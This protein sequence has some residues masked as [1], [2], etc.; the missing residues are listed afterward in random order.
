M[1]HSNGT[2]A[3]IKYV[4]NL[5]LFENVVLFDVLVVPEYRVS[6]LSVNKLIR[7]SRMFVGFTESKSYIPDFHLNKIVGTSS[8]NDGL[9]M[10]DSNSLISSNSQTIGNLNG[11]CFV[12]KSL[13]HNTLGHPSDQ[14]IDV[15]QSDLKFTKDSHI[16]PCDICHK[17]KQTR[18]PF[19]LSD[20]KT[21]VIGELVHID[22][23]EP[24]KVISKYSF[25]LGIVHQTTRAYTPQ[26]NEV[27]EKKHKHLLNV[28]KMCSYWFSTTK[29]AYK[30]YSRESKLVFYSRDVK[31]YET[32]F[33][34]NMKSSLQFLKENHVNNIKNLIFFN[35]KH[36]DD[37]T[38]SLSPYDDGR[39]SSAPNDDGN[40]QPCT[41]G[42][43]NRNNNWTICDLPKGR[44]AVGSKW[45]FK[46]KY[47][48]TGAIDR[49]KARLVAKGFNQRDGFDYM[50]TFSPV[51]KMST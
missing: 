40:V 50:E 37:Q 27:A 13:W 49:Y 39:V 18:E 42:S 1:V 8:E 29:K 43:L 4:G 31:F 30:L 26:Q 22:L 36:L 21:T 41:T 46:I 34:Y 17:T 9:Y 20:H 25:S 48:S 15:L 7:D 35:E 3:K 23:W 11:T 38:S 45:L 6:L 44:K 19:P 24:Y 32:V 33:L 14:A 16:S 51:V 10:F 47:K 2:L 28:K 5:K 12:S